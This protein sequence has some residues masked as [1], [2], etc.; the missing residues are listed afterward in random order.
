LIFDSLSGGLCRA[1]VTATLRDWLE[2]E[3]IAK[4]KDETKNFS[5]N[6]FKASLVKVPQQPNLYDCGLFALYYFKLFFDVSLLV[7][8]IV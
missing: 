5:P 3:Y 2:Q 8:I 4:Y 6:I 1:R 7:F